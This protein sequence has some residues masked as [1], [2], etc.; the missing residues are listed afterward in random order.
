[1]GWGVRGVSGLG[2]RCVKGDLWVCEAPWNR[3]TNQPANQPA[4]Q[5]R[6]VFHLRK[7]TWLRFRSPSA[8]T[9]CGE[10]GGCEFLHTCVCMR[11]CMCACVCVCVHARVYVHMS[12]YV[13]D[14]PPAFIRLYMCFGVHVSTW[15]IHIEMRIYVCLLSKIYLYIYALHF[16]SNRYI[17]CI[18][19]YYGRHY[20]IKKL[21]TCSRNVKDLLMCLASMATCTQGVKMRGPLIIIRDLY[22]QMQILHRL[23]RL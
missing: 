1:M 22:L 4:N 2:V 23:T 7:G 21:R 11:V 20:I 12:V 9:T 16:L 10:E 18:Y 17:A 19:V 13:C 15:Y 6:S 3:L 14:F 8:T 5:P